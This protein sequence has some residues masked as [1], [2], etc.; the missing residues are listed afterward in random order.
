MLENKRSRVLDSD[1][2]ELSL[3]NDYD[4]WQKAKKHFS[5]VINKLL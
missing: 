3:G 1:D 5:E 2:E 4:Q